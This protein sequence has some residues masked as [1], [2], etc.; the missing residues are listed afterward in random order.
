MNNKNLSKKW[1]YTFI[2]IAIA[3]LA[4]CVVG[5]YNKEYIIANRTAFVFVSKVFNI[6]KWKRN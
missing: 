2:I 1:L 4:T 5:L 3:A 6:I